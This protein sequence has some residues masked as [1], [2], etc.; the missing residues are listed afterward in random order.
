PRKAHRPIASGALP[1]GVAAVGGLAL[2][3]SGCALGWLLGPACLGVLALYLAMN[4]AYSLWLKHVVLADVMVIALGFVLRV[5]AGV[6][7][8]QAEPTTR[9]MLCIFFL[10]LLLGAAKRR[11]ELVALGERAA[12]HRP[13]LAKYTVGYVDALLGVMAVMTIDSYVEYAVGGE[14]H[15]ATLVI[16]VPPVVYGI[17]RFLLLVLV[18]G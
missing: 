13:V 3:A 11:A 17:A 5:L 1:V 10:A 14:N 7:A 9:I 16:T 8:V 18:R 15:P 6:Y 12:A 2:A 4:L